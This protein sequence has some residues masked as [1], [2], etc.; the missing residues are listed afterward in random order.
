[1]FAA[2]R[3]GIRNEALAERSEEE[4]AG[5]PP[6]EGGVGPEELSL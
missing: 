3:P 2:A 6:K 5:M 4:A 1:V